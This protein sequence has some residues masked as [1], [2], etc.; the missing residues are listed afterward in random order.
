MR[1]DVHC[2]AVGKGKNIDEIENKV[3]FNI[4]DEPNWFTR[5]FYNFLYNDILER[6]LIKL[7]GDTDDNDGWISTDEYFDFV[8][9]LL[10]DSTEIDGIVLLAFDAVYTNDGEVD[11]IPTDIWVSNHFL[12]GRVIELNKR[13]QAKNI[14]N[15]R[16]FFGASVNPNNSKWERELDFVLNGTDAVL[17]K[18]IPSAQHIQVQKVEPEFYKRL[19]KKE[20]P[21]L[22]HV[23]TEHTFPE[24]MR[25]KKNDHFRHL[26]I[27]LNAGVKVIAAHCNTP[28][29]PLLEKNEI[30]DFRE[31]MEK[32]NKDE[33][34]LYADTSALCSI[35]KS[36][37]LPDITKTFN[38][39]WLIHGSDFPIPITGWVNLP[40]LRRDIT[41]DEYKEIINCE[42][43]FDQDVIIKRAYGMNDS[44]L[45][46]VEN[47]LRMPHA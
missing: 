24:G 47:I 10:K 21:I 4:N 17:I 36:H 28:S 44:I 31:F 27:P 12:N 42:N 1:I 19:A 45:E 18:W 37:Y 7:G 39:E 8:Y 41:I 6:E 3:Y 38:H 2:H 5:R 25:Q 35:T 22:S 13:F 11:E 9:R 23:G 30:E 14:Q 32:E 16:F 29:I 34:R 15:K 46:N 43:P 26:E 33:I 40:L 20:M